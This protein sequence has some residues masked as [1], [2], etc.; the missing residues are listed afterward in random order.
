MEQSGKML[1]LVRIRSVALVALGILTLACGGKSPSTPTTPQVP[2]TPT[3]PTPPPPPPPVVLDGRLSDTATGQPLPD[4]T[5]DL[6]GRV[7]TTTADG[8]FRYEVPIGTLSPWTTV[9]LNA[10]GIL[11]RTLVLLTPGSRTVGIDAIS[12]S[13][14]FDLEYYRRFVRDS[15][16]SPGV[17]RTLRRWAQAPRVYVRTVDQ[18]GNAIDPVTLNT[19][20]EALQDEASAWTGGRFGLAGVEVGTET[21]EGMSGWITARWIAPLGDDTFCARAQIA[22]NGGWMEFNHLM[23]TGCD[24]RGSRIGAKTV[25]H[26]LGHAMGFFHTGDR[27]DVMWSSAVCEDRRP[28]ARERL[29]AA[30]AYGRAVGNADPDVDPATAV[31]SYEPPL[32]IVD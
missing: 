9:K 5:V 8:S 21:R 18:Q 23:P 1:A 17:L 27:N 26:E 4:V 22:V 15:Y 29:H 3:T 12:L 24:C 7:T 16:D 31:Q 11:E 14:G 19:V 20:V 10:P 2:T 13:T 6:E 32:V 30:I 25:R 28:S